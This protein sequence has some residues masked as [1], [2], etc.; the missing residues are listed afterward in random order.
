MVPL[1]V[2]MAVIEPMDKVEEFPRSA[3]MLTS[4]IL[5]SWTARALPIIGAVIS[6]LSVPTAPVPVF[7]VTPCVLLDCAVIV[8]D[9]PKA[10]LPM[11]AFTRA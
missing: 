8:P 4:V 5:P 11:T 1:L 9:C 2:T 7:P 10:S 6:A 3:R